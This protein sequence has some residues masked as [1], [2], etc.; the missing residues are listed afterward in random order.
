MLFKADNDVGELSSPS[1]APAIANAVFRLSGKRLRE[2]PFD[3]RA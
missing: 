2:T 3:L 1:V